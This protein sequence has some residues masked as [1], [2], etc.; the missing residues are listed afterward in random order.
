M[1][2]ILQELSKDLNYQF[3]LYKVLACSKQDGFLGN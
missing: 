1:E 2:N 3:T